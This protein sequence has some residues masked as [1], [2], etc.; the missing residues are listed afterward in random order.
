MLPEIAK[1]YWEKRLHHLT[2]QDRRLSNRLADVKTLNQRM[3]LQTVNGE[4]SAE[5]FATVKEAVTQQKS[6]VEAQL[7]VLDA[8]TTIHGLLE[9]TQHNI[10][11]LAKAWNNKTEQQ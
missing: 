11:D 4:L 8:E 9:E 3:L 6:D 2:N 10:V 7:N 1:K 5:N